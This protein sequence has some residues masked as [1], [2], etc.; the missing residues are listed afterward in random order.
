MLDAGDGAG[1]LHR[2]H[3]SCHQEPDVQA[4]SA[5][6]LDVL[7]T[8]RAKNIWGLGLGAVQVGRD[9]G[10]RGRHL[11]AGGFAL[12]LSLP[13]PS[14]PSQHTPCNTN[15]KIYTSVHDCH[16]C[17][18]LCLPAFVPFICSL[19]IGKS[20]LYCAI[21]TM[22]CFLSSPFSSPLP[23]SPFF[24][25]WFCFLT[26][27]STLS[28]LHLF[29]PF[30]ISHPFLSTLSFMQWNNEVKHLMPPKSRWALQN[31]NIL[32]TQETLGICISKLNWTNR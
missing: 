13:P 19:T 27:T 24:S 25:S 14:S 3:S 12:P 5:G 18:D 1:N 16:L 22:C 15:L 20:S 31:A 7:G 8:H 10:K 6:V 32:T 23:L 21:S 2:A 4:R 17:T 11:S 26:S 29:H 30:L 28:R 9:W